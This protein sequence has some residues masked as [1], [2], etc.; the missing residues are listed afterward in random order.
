MPNLRQ[1]KAAKNFVEAIQSGEVITAGEILKRSD[2]A[3]SVQK[4][5]HAVFE[6]EGFKE[7]LEEIG[8]TEDNAKK[9]VAEIMLNENVNPS[10]R[11]EAAKEV[12]KVHGTYAPEKHVN[13]NLNLELIQKKQSRLYQEIQEESE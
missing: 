1:R 6:S 8:F 10:A 7:A 11:L 4:V 3:E 2:Y 9:V 5:P 12:F 13:T